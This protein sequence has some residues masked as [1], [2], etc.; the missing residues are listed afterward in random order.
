MQIKNEMVEIT[1]L[2]EDMIV[3][4]EFLRTSQNSY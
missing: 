3:D 4:V 1:L 2:L